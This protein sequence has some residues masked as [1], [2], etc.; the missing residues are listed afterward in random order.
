MTFA[1][2]IVEAPQMNRLLTVCGSLLMALAFASQVFAQA[3]L[4]IDSPAIQAIKAKMQQRHAQLAPA[5]QSGAVGLT[6]DGNVQVRDANALPLKDRAAVSGLVGQENQDR[7]A[8]YREIAK[9]NNH[10]EWE[11][12]IRN[13]FAQ[14]WVQKAQSGWYYQDPNG[15]WAKK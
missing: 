13:T 3:N 11:G 12:D 1:Q 2:R 14:R 8:L 10:P 9:A 5:Y 4:D 7:A 15:N 6:R